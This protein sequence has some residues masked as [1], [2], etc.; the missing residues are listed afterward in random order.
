MKRHYFKPNQRNY[1]E[2][3][4]GEKET[5]KNEKINKLKFEKLLKR[6]HQIIKKQEWNKK[7]PD[8]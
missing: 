3:Y 2:G 5:K 7:Q 8:D 1:Y 6:Q 4:R